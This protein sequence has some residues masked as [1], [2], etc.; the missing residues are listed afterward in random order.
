MP[1]TIPVGTHKIPHNHES[2]KD[3]SGE[4]IYQLA[5]ILARPDGFPRVATCEDC[6][7]SLARAIQRTFEDWQGE[8][9]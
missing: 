5:L 3:L 7:E 8:L 1:R 6:I 9:K 4:E 2:S